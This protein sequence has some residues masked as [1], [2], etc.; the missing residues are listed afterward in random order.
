MSGNL[1]FSAIDGVVCQPLLKEMWM[2]NFHQFISNGF[3]DGINP[4]DFG[5]PHIAE[6]AMVAFV[7]RFLRKKAEKQEYITPSYTLIGKMRLSRVALA[8]KAFLADEH[9]ILMARMIFPNF[10]AG[11]LF[12][13][14]SKSNV[15]IG[16][17]RLLTAGDR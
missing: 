8:K 1:A 2:T 6:N 13:Q 14:I 17:W 12:Y 5:N 7:S 10:L 3:V 16:R 4:V 9:R 15:L 11:C